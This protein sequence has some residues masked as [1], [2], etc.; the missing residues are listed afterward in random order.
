MRKA[1]LMLFL[2]IAGALLNIALNMLCTKFGI[3]LYLDTV[4]TV[5]LT[6]AGGLFWGVL[7]GALT[8]LI[9]H[10][11]QFWGWEGYLFALCNI[12]TAI[13]TY[14]FIRLFPNE[15]GH[16]GRRNVLQEETG[17]EIFGVP[18]KNTF[19][20][21]LRLGKAM[22]RM[23]VLILLS[24][25]L[26]I[27]MS[28]LGGLLTVLILV[29]RNPADPN[30]ASVLLSSTLFG[31]SVPIILKEILSR[32]PINIIDRLLT[33]FGGYGIVYAITV[34]KETTVVDRLHI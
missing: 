32:I 29:L 12:A 20:R 28:V 18:A 25:S 2:C 1:A 30:P 11:I 5:T 3:P 9:G 31:D 24:F 15:L 14:L 10:S 16:A 33:A 23:M 8:N 19:L 26:C 27:A 13:I 17:Q 6:L 34:C 22:D 4:L 21:S 7:T